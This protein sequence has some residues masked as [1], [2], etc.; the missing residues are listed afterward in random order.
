MSSVKD[1][2]TV[3]T[4]YKLIYNKNRIYKEAFEECLKDYNCSSNFGDEAKVRNDIHNEIWTNTSTKDDE[5]YELDDA[6]ASAYMDGKD[7][8]YEYYHNYFTHMISIT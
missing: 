8:L 7:E 6:F 1:T 2:S 4:S 3:I 5:K